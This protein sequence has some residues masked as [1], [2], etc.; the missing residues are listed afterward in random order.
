[1]TNELDPYRYSRLQEI[2]D[3]MFNEGR[4]CNEENMAQ[5]ILDHNKLPGLSRD[6]LKDTV[7]AFIEDTRRNYMTINQMAIALVSIGACYAVSSAKCVLAS[8][9]PMSK[10]SYHIHPDSSNPQQ[11][12]IVRIYSQKQFQDWIRTAKAVKRV[13]DNEQ[14]FGL[15]S[16]YE[17]RWS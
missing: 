8:D 5:F 10:P 4:V 17:D 16:S 6:D 2:F 9:P 3:E 12:D 1:M 13:N 14:S 11:N 7:H 15:W